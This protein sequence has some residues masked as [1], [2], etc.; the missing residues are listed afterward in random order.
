MIPAATMLDIADGR[1]SNAEL[2]SQIDTPCI[3]G[4]DEA[5]ICLGELGIAMIRALSL[6]AS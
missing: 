6:L 2:L 5:D 1:L 3:A 4:L